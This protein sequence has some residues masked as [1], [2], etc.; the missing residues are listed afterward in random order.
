MPGGD[1]DYNDKNWGKTN[2]ETKYSTYYE[3]DYKYATKTKSEVYPYV[4]K[5]PTYYEKTVYETKYITKTETY[6]A[7]K[8][9]VKS[10]VDCKTKWYNNHWDY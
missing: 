1:Y 9:S 6:P 7:T 4:T 3:T 10:E 8:S 2:C 5:V